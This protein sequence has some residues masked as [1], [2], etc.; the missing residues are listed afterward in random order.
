MDKFQ[1]LPVDGGRIP[2]D[3]CVKRARSNHYEYIGRQ[4]GG[5]CFMGTT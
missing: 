3:D 2:M 4:D 1:A 5:Q